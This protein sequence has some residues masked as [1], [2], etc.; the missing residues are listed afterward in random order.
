[1][2]GRLLQVLVVM[3]LLAV[4]QVAKQNKLDLILQTLVPFFH[5]ERLGLEMTFG[6][7]L[8]ADFRMQEAHFEL[9]EEHRADNLVLYPRHL[10]G[11]C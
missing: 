9:L 2:V 10:R 3:A 5:D 7:F 11:V 4:G 8:V 6:R 1:M